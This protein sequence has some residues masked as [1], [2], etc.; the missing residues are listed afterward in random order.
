[1]TNF[2][3]EADKQRIAEFIATPKYERVPEMLIPE[4]EE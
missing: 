4:E 3:S 2:L 1:M